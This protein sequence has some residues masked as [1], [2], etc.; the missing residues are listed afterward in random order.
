MRRARDVQ[1]VSIPGVC[2]PGE[3]HHFP[4]LVREL[5][6]GKMVVN[7]GNGKTRA[8]NIYI[9][10]LVAAHLHAADRLGEGTQVGGRA[11][12]ITDGEP[13]HYFQFFRPA[14][15]ALGHK[16]PR[17]NLPGG[18]LIGLAWV[19]EAVHLLGGPAPFTTVMEAQK[20]VQEDWVH[21]DNAR[22]D[23]E[24]EP[25]V[26]HAEGMARSLPYIRELYA[27]A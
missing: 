7:L 23:L 26:S 8:D 4:R 11:Y 22:R 25:K 2:G 27:N 3:E 13:Q 9:D 21:I 16:M 19:S 15:E 17:F 12:F 20:L 24:W 18:V 1:E 5:K 10:D 14:I 6:A